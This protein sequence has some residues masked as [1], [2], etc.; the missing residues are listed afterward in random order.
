MIIEGEVCDLNAII[1]LHM[2]DFRVASLC[3]M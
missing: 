3:E 2:T 1:K